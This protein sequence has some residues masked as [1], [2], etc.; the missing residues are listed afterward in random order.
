MHSAYVPCPSPFLLADVFLNVFEICLFLCHGVV[1]CLLPFP[2][3]CPLQASQKFAKVPICLFMRAYI[4]VFSAV[5]TSKKKEAK[6]SK[7]KEKYH[8]NSSECCACP[9]SKSE[10]AAEAKRLEMEIFFEDVLHG[11]MYC[12]R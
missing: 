4:Y 9:K 3:H 2:F 10:L 8:N 11:S 5:V 1:F 6:G 7:E 12:Q